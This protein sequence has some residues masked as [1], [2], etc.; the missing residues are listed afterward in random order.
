MLTNDASSTEIL[1]DT[2][3]RSIFENSLQG[4]LL[5]KY[6]VFTILQAN[7]AIAK[8]LG[9]DANELVTRK[10]DTLMN[11]DEWTYTLA[12]IQNLVD[13]SAS[14]DV[15]INKYLAKNGEWVTLKV[16]FSILNNS[17]QPILILTF[18]EIDT[19][20]NPSLLKIEKKEYEAYMLS[21]LNSLEGASVLLD[22]NRIILMTNQAMA[23]RYESTIDSLIGRNALSF[24]SPEIAT[25]RNEK[26]Q[27]VIDELKEISFEENYNNRILQNTIRP[28]FD[29]SQNLICLAVYSLDITENRKIQHEAIIKNFAVDES[30]NGIAFGDLGGNLFYVN[31]SFLKLWKY[32]NKDEVIGKSAF[33]FWKSPD[34]AKLVVDAILEF[35]VWD[36]EM[37]A[38]LN[39]GAEAVFQVSAKILVDA[40]GKPLALNASFLDITE[41]KYA[42]NKLK[43]SEEQLRLALKSAN[44]GLYDLNLITG[45]A[46]VS[47]EYATMLGF[48]PKDFH[49]TNDFWRERLHPDD[50]DVVYKTYE[51]YIKGEVEEYGVEFRQ[52]TSSG[53]WKWILSSGKIVAYNSNG[54]PTRMLGTHT[55]ISRLKAIELDAKEGRQRLKTVVNNAPIVL[56]SVDRQGVFTLS[57][58]KGLELLGLKPHQVVGLSAFEMYKDYPEIL[59]CLKSAINGETVRYTSKIGTVFFD[60]VYAPIIGL[61]NEIIGATGIGIDITDKMKAE[62]L[63]NEKVKELN[64]IIEALDQSSLVSLTDKK[65]IIV[66]VNDRFCEV[67]GYSREEL[68]GK[69]HRIIN[70]KYH[71]KSFWKEVWKVINHGDVWRGEVKNAHKNGRTYW[72]DTVINPIK[73]NT[74][75]ITHFLSI[76]QDITDRKTFEDLLL[77]SNH[78]LAQIEKFIDFTTD[79]IQ[80]TD[81]DGQLVYLNQAASNRLGI[82]KEDCSRHN[83]VDIEELFSNKNDWFEHIIKLRK[84]GFLQVEGIHLNRQTNRVIPVEISVSLITIQGKE[85]VIA[86]SRD[87]TA[88]KEAEKQ[89]Q[90]NRARLA[91][92]QRMANLGY[93]EYDL[94]TNQVW[95]SEEQYKINGIKSTALPVTQQ[96]FVKLVHPE[97]REVL[98]DKLNEV[99]SSGS[100]LFNKYRIIRPDGEIRFISSIAH[101]TADE[102]GK[103]LRISGVNQDITDSIVAENALR[104]SELTLR[105]AQA[106]AKIGSW[107]LDVKNN[108]LEWSDEA[109]KIFNAPLAQKLTYDDFLSYVHPEDRAYV[110]DSWSAALNGN[111]YDITHRIIVKGDVKWVHEQA[112]LSFDELN[113]LVLGFGTVQDITDQKIIQDTNRIFNQSLFFTGLGSWRISFRSND[114][115]WSDNVYNLHGLIKDN[116]GLNLQA[117]LETIH[118][119]DRERILTEAIAAMKKITSFETEYRV[120]T[121]TEETRWLLVKGGCLSD[122]DGSLIEMY[123][124]VRDITLEKKNLDELIIAKK[125]AE[126]AAQ[127]KDEFLS[128]MSHEIRTPLNSVIGLS[129]LL[130]KRS[131]R[132]DQ[133]EIV[134]TLK[135]SADN[136]LH[137]V[138]DIL[139][140]NKIRAGKLDLEIRSFSLANFLKHLHSS[141]NIIASDKNIELKIKIDAQIPNNLY[142][143]ITRLNQIFNNLLGNAIKFTRKGHVCLRADLKKKSNNQCTIIFRVEDT[144]VGIAADKLDIIFK[145][146]HQSESDTTRKFGGTGLGLSIVRALVTLLNGKIQVS[147]TVNRG[148]VFLIELSFK[149]TALKEKK[150]I[151]HMKED[152]FS[153]PP[154]SKKLKLL[155]VEDVESNRFLVENTLADHGVRVS[156]VPSGKA[157]LEISKGE[158]FDLILMDIQMPGM[159]GYQ[160]TQQIR[161]QFRGKNKKT[162]V[163]AFTAE[164]YSEQLK[165]KVV[166]NGMQDV[167]TKPFDTE[168]LI[169]KI[170]SALKSSVLPDKLFSF[171][172][173]AN[174]F[175]NDPAKVKKIKTAVVKDINRFHT[176]LTL[177]TSKGNIVGIRNEIHRIRPILKNLECQSLLTLIN[178]LKAD[179]EINAETKKIIN[180]IIRVTKRIE[181]KISKLKY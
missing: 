20:Q 36:G 145:P 57:D 68:I 8:V 46:I 181:M 88:R 62:L 102:N 132:E 152:V 167:L 124:I 101:L 51:A 113:N 22:T 19:L 160:T 103:P 148:S 56:F 71:S 138:N 74:G 178:S 162:P 129:N 110:Q 48:D 3:Y 79:A 77:Q 38:I 75:E 10:L 112:E 32:T 128:V 93:W 91:E 154:L 140:Y 29:A 39:D 81:L 6:E 31:K 133:L 26:I 12:S 33:T 85:F 98:L 21:L 131:P 27:K 179:D 43:E 80:V 45:D 83:I 111:A 34:Q 25:L 82:G 89:S 90:E 146:F 61:K 11:P 70:S 149:Y 151:Q 135:S 86:I 173:Y 47:P 49:E 121:S 64:N 174:A 96:D 168:L 175:S 106:V 155:Y 50:Q 1:N 156:T 115:F 95:W 127:I 4:I 125:E 114:Y 171:L 97:D 15:R 165:I 53:E 58:G 5:V 118:A 139:D 150:S 14:S 143:D 94:I 92:A 42:E 159:D 177:F 134:K 78:R 41:A 72:V 60:A 176:K 55:D 69:S 137:L 117:Y 7:R 37:V 141:F 153:S 35:G 99:I 170:H 122:Q 136:L 172:F 16:Q 13:S 126:E 119:D 158:V 59:R 18:Q 116:A 123:G 24:F 40:D 108:I 63:A 65:G 76:R 169:S 100:E 104:E 23:D 157:A 9:Y 164:P 2:I 105:R 87:I 30:I 52:K 147:S 73:D 130:I 54:Q 28:I 163:L 120:I 166:Q 144:G 142:G 44:Q 67:S 161:Q 109:Y 107:K 84:K 17:E 180:T 66:K